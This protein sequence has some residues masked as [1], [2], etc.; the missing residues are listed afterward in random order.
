MPLKSVKAWKFILPAGLLLVLVQ[1]L[2]QVAE[3][4]DYLFP[5]KHFRSELE[6]VGDKCLFMEADLISLR[7][8]VHDLE[9]F[10]ASNTPDRRPSGASLVLSPWSEGVR[11]FFPKFFWNF[12]IYQAKRTRVKVERNVRYVDSMLNNL[13]LMKPAFPPNSARQ[14]ALKHDPD[15]Q[16]QKIRARCQFCASEVK[17][18]SEKLNGLEM[19]AKNL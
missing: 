9:A 5:G 18:L 4:Q 16:I 17:R 13:E 11:F 3:F 12:N 1:G 15:F 14:G 19:R 6:A 7:G 10:L 2:L 8:R